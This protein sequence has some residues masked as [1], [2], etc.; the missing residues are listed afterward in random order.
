MLVGE[1]IFISVASFFPFD[2][3]GCHFVCVGLSVW[4]IVCRL[5]E[6]SCGRE[7]ETTRVQ[8][9]RDMIDKLVIVESARSIVCL[10]L[11]RSDPL[12]TEH[13]MSQC[14]RQCDRYGTREA[15]CRV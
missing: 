10:R 1:E 5:E 13:D 2:P 11:E 7:V 9:I 15:R 14:G 4:E 8:V 12:I 3:L 6:Y